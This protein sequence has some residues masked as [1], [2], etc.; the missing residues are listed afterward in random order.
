[1]QK[2]L[3]VLAIVFYVIHGAVHVRRG[4]PYD[5]L[6]ACHVAAIFVGVGLLLNNATLNAIG[7]LWACFG[8]PLWLVDVFTGGEF[9]P[10]ASLTHIGALVIGI[11]G[12]RRMGMQRGSGWKALAAYVVL[13]IMTR[14]ITPS[15]ANINLAFRVQPG[16]EPRFP[17]FPLYFAMLF[18]AGAVTFMAG[19][20]AFAR[21]MAKERSA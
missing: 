8:I 18:L 19:E 20:Y 3:G 9:M 12:V 13:W 4:E 7:L 16:W 15:A 17:S 6:W 21:V 10:T 11:Y 5:L 14:A 1:M 2:T